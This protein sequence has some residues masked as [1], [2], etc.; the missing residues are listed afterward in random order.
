MKKFRFGALTKTFVLT[1][2]FVTNLSSQEVS[3]QIVNSDE[4]ETL[5]LA[6]TCS[7]SGHSDDCFDEEDSKNKRY[8]LNFNAFP[9]FNYNKGRG[10]YNQSH[11]KIQNCKKRKSNPDQSELEKLFSG[12]T[13]KVEDSKA[14]I[15]GAI[16][17]KGLPV[18]GELALTGLNFGIFPSMDTN[19]RVSRYVKGYENAK[20]LPDSIVFPE[21][22]QQV[23]SFNPRDTLSYTT[24]GAISLVVG[25]GAYGASIGV[26]ATIGGIWDI[27]IRKINNNQQK[28]RITISKSKILGGRI[29]GGIIAFANIYGDIE[30][31]LQKSIVIEL[32]LTD[33]VA[34]KLY[35]D[36]VNG[37]VDEVQKIVEKEKNEAIQLKQFSDRNGLRKSYG[38]SAGIPFLITGG[39]S[40]SQNDQLINV[41]KYGN[42]EKNVEMENY[43]STRLHHQDFKRLRNITNSYTRQFKPFKHED[44]LKLDLGVS[45]KVQTKTKENIF[46]SDLKG[47]EIHE[48]EF[49][50]SVV[51]YKNDSAYVEEILKA[52]KLMEEYSYL[53][54]PIPQ[55]WPEKHY[56]G[57]V[58]ME[59]IL[60]FPETALT[61]L[62]TLLRDESFF[63]QIVT[64]SKNIILDYF[65]KNDFRNICSEIELETEKKDCINKVIEQTESDI[66]TLNNKID[67]LELASDERS[68]KSE[69]VSEIMRLCR[70]N[71]FLVGTLKKFIKEIQS[72]ITIEGELF[73]KLHI[74]N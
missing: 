66:Y 11:L 56:L 70:K 5:S 31:A 1:C 12:D 24:K 53:R 64:D 19:I 25:V 39:M 40:H 57:S 17:G 20:N 27:Q 41:V 2:L 4:D 45:S 29:R 23:I 74:R 47:I 6:S 49:G 7:S 14:T 55:I 42:V 10:I 34:Q 65:S 3:D 22:Y 44:Y 46:E 48:G 36:I 21:T 59:S 51:L 58:L 28:V 32:H 62:K 26:N 68:L 60:K 71:P 16:L 38:M 37:S 13:F 67:Q 15:V 72:E 52:K 63:K 33:S 50:E 61:N 18:F 69:I 54:D 30:K 8:T 9:V 73:R 35:A 43:V